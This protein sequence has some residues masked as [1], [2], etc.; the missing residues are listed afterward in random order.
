MSIKTQ[1]I[2]T[3]I[4]NSADDMGYFVKHNPIMIQ[5]LKI[6]NDTSNERF[7]VEA[8]KHLPFIKKS[9]DSIVNWIKNNESFLILPDYD[10]DWTVSWFLYYNML[11]LLKEVYHSSSTIRIKPTARD[12]GYWISNK[13]FNS[14]LHKE[15]DN[16]ITTDIGITVEFPMDFISSKKKVIVFDHHTPLSSIW[17]SIKEFRH[18]YLERHP[19][20]NIN[21]KYIKDID[22]LKKDLTDFFERHPNFSQKFRDTFI[23]NNY[24]LNHYPT[25]YL[26][27]DE[28]K[29]QDKTKDTPSIQENYEKIFYSSAW[30]LAVSVYEYALECLVQEKLLSDNMKKLIHYIWIGWAITAISD[31]TDLSSCNNMYFFIHGQ[32]VVNHLQ[33]EL[34]RKD[35]EPTKDNILNIIKSTLNIEPFQNWNPKWFE[36]IGYFLSWLLSFKNKFSHSDLGFSICPSINAYGRVSIMHSLFLEWIIGDSW[37]L[38]ANKISFN[39]VRKQLQTTITRQVLDDIKKNKRF[40]HLIVIGWVKEQISDWEIDKA[41]NKLKSYFAQHYSDIFLD[42]SWEDI[43]EDQVEW[44]EFDIMK[45]HE[46]VF[47]I[48][49]SKIAEMYKKPSFVGKYCKEKQFRGSWRSIFSLFDLWC[50]TFETVSNL[51]WHAAAF[52]IALKDVDGFIEEISKKLETLTDEEKQKLYTIKMDVLMNI[53]PNVRDILTF[54]KFFTKFDGF[55]KSDANFEAFKDYKVEDIQ[56]LGKEWATV[57]ILLKNWENEITFLLWNFW[58]FCEKYDLEIP[59]INASEIWENE[60]QNFTL[61]VESEDWGEL[62]KTKILTENLNI[63][64][65]QTQGMKLEDEKYINSIFFIW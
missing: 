18:F 16:I 39:D 20:A 49:A 54:E 40:E 8:K 5:S 25:Y 41:Y 1:T 24:V 21:E 14:D 22:E 2:Y 53:K 61:S 44:I 29:I 35:L 59:K 63:S 15:V 42:Y 65:I 30:E 57:K 45:N 48:I 38:R 51:W 26:Y 55:V 28:A 19:N 36:Q 13:F 50:T 56:F 11:N 23:M 17:F 9:F 47:W 31:V 64:N 43:Q 52:G 7:T 37:V 4:V 12:E 34:I 3:N 33:K 62:L 27:F 10:A 60:K 6:A 46:W 32:K 58:W